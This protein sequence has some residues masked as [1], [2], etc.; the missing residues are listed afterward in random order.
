MTD[1]RDQRAQLRRGRWARA[2]PI[3]G[4]FWERSPSIAGFDHAT[5]LTYCSN[6]VVDGFDD[7]RLP[8]YLELV[9]IADFGRVGPAFTSTAFGHSVQLSKLLDQHGARR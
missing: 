6:L 7:W 4:L 2:D 5:A 1:L 3:T 8:T 9:S